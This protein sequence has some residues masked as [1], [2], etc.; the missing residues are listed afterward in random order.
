MASP[1]WSILSAAKTA[2]E[3]ISAFSGVTVAIRKH[4]F[5]SKDHDGALPMVVVAPLKEDVDEYDR[6]T[7][8][9]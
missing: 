2:L 7:A 1:Q 4:I 5:Y 3:G 8:K 9:Q 6:R